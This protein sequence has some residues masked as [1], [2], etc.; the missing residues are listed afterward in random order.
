MMLWSCLTKPKC[1]TWKHPPVPWRPREV[2]FLPTR[3]GCSLGAWVWGGAELAGRL[4]DISRKPGSS[5]YLSVTQE[6]VHPTPPWGSSSS[7]L[8]GSCSPHCMC[9]FHHRCP[10]ETPLS[11]EHRSPRQVVGSQHRWWQG[12]VRRTMWCSLFISTLKECGIQRVLDSG[13]LNPSSPS[14]PRSSSLRRHKD[15]AALLWAG[16]H[17]RKKES[18]GTERSWSRLWGAVWK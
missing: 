16:G 1:N 13:S 6:P 10:Q 11:Q 2:R 15:A 12:T 18:V 5:W 3:S 17:L 8:P 9:A 14:A 4:S 7:C